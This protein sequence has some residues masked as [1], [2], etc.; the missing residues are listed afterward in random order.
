MPV[1]SG[2]QKPL[3]SDPWEF[4]LKCVITFDERAGELGL[5][6]ERLFPEK[7]YLEVLC[8]EQQN[9]RF[10]I[11]TRI[12]AAYEK[13]LARIAD[14]ELLVY[15]D[16]VVKLPTSRIVPMAEHVL[17][18]TARLFP[19]AQCLDFGDPAEKRS[20]RRPAQAVSSFGSQ[21]GFS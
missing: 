13:P 20:M 8:R 15:H 3:P 18:E 11:Y 10:L 1:C 12:P 14:G 5:P 19:G 21:R 16:G 4:L 2:A 7:P 6:P 17:T 9:H